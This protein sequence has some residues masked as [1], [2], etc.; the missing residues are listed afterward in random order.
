MP[1]KPSNTQ[2]KPTPR[3]VPSP[4]PAPKKTNTTTP[5]VKPS[6][7]PSAPTK[8]N[9]EL[10]V[11]SF[12]RQFYFD[13]KTMSQLYN[14]ND[15]E[16][17]VKFTIR[18][19]KD[20]GISLPE[21]YVMFVYKLFNN[22]IQK[23]SVPTK[24]SDVVSKMD[25]MEQLI[26]L[27]NL[28]SEQSKKTHTTFVVK[29]GKLV[30]PPTTVDQSNVTLDTVVSSQGYVNL[31]G[32]VDGS[33]PEESPAV[34]E[35]KKKLGYTVETGNVMTDDFVKFLKNWQGQNQITPTGAIDYKTV[36]KLY[37]EK[38]PKIS[39]PEGEKPTTNTKTTTNVVA[40]EN[41]TNIKK[42]LEK[43]MISANRIMSPA[44]GEDVNFDYCKDLFNNYPQEVRMLKRDL[45]VKIDITNDELTTLITPIK[46]NVER[47]YKRCKSQYSTKTA[48]NKTG[49]WLNIF[50]KGSASFDNLDE[51]FK[52]EA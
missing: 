41:E 32:S 21:A 45:G 16:R 33:L 25:L 1:V 35:I 42:T 28:L 4:S 14:E 39:S 44:R 20:L 43:S 52:I 51:P 10:E 48:L 46:N 6:N 9:E 29:N 3:P 40:N 37:P 18:D 27:G 22:N 2:K 30:P 31:D 36:I 15:L 19:S 38:T 34:A 12:T 17:L 23:I 24:Y 11:E 7:T 13:G 49:D 5:V 26:G 8:S 50:K 47:A